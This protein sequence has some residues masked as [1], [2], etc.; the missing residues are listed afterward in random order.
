M[1]T[2]SLQIRAQATAVIGDVRLAMKWLATPSAVFEGSTPLAASDTPEGYHRVMRQLSWFA[3]KPYH[4]QASAGRG[5][6]TVADLLSDPIMEIVLRRAGSG[7]EELLRLCRQ[8]VAPR[9][10]A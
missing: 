3:G 8:A 5:E 9:R 10:A 7:P 6:E 4:D 2:H 1:S